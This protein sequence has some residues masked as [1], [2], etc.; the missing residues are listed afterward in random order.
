MTDQDQNQVEGVDV[1]FLIALDEEFRTLQERVPS[2]SPAVNPEYGDDDYLFDVEFSEGTSYR[3]VASLIDDMG[4]GHAGDATHRVLAWKP[5]I[6]INVGLAASLK[7]DDIRLCDV[8]VVNSAVEYVAKG[9]V[10][11]R[12]GELEFERGGE[13]YRVDPVL[14]RS[15][16]HLEFGDSKRFDGWKAICSS[17]IAEQI[18][19]PIRERLMS[20][21]K[22]RLEPALAKCDLA[23]GPLVAAASRFKEWV[24]SGNRNI[25]ALE[26][27]AAGVLR[28]LVSRPTRAKALVIRGI[29][30]LA[31]A[32]K[33]ELDG[34][35]DG[36]LRRIAMNN[37]LD[38]IWVLM[39]TGR[40]QSDRGYGGV[41]R[42]PAEKRTSG[43]DFEDLKVGIRDVNASVTQL[44]L[45]AL[46]HAR[47]NGDRSFAT[48]LR[49]ELDGYQNSD[50]ILPEYRKIA[51]QS[52]AHLY[53]GSREVR[54]L[55]IPMQN[56]E[57]NIDMR[58]ELPEGV[59]ENLIGAVRDLAFCQLTV[60]LAEVER[61]AQESDSAHAPWPDFVTVHAL[62]YITEITP[63]QAWQ[64]IPRTAFQR[65]LDCVRNRIFD[66]VYP[67]IENSQL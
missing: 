19:E 37:A 29:S 46:A 26:M 43:S 61:L 1:A 28:A 6:V 2:W 11:E 39:E 21:R 34:I 44:A 8:V 52:K 48:W 57:M 56:L 53:N 64:V 10:S 35:A 51:V 50:A 5:A 63:I 45:H 16:R 36:T 32:S 67:D 17:R 42:M 62:R 58:R 20:E 59:R 13:Y 12:D 4:T 24:V 3:C 60:G 55:P 14:T 33:S 47:A 27:E 18:P 7:S 40:L 9:K 25:K 65:V 15:V 31:D 41:F 54:N 22:I 38:L 30:D 66:Y 23:S 49:Q